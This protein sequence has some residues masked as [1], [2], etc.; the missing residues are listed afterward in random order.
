MLIFLFLRGLPFAPPIEPNPLFSPERR[1]R[2][3]RAGGA[4]P[5]RLGPRPRPRCERGPRRRPFER[6]LPAPRGPRPAPSPRAPEGGALPGAAQTHVES[7][8][9]L[10]CFSSW[11]EPGGDRPGLPGPRALKPRGRGREGGLVLRFPSSGS[12]HGP[13]PP[14]RARGR[15]IPGAGEADALGQARG[16]P[17]K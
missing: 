8:C 2:K 7:G 10:F 1:E 3:C 11:K 14:G 17:G 15:W 5:P 6:P 12:G 4:C 16:L 13:G 9:V